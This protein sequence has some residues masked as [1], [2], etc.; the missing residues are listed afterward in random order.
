MSCARSLAE[1]AAVRELAA[2]VDGPGRPAWYWRADLEA[3]AGGRALHARARYG[4]AL[5]DK[6]YYRPTEQWVDHPGGDGVR[7]R[8]WTYQPPSGV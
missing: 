8:A 5:A 6:C 3:P 7:G 2:L 4:Q 1:Q